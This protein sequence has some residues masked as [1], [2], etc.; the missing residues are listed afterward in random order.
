VQAAFSDAL[1]AGND[2]SGMEDMRVRLRARIGAAIYSFFAAGGAAG[3]TA[4]VAGF[5]GAAGVAEAAGAAWA[6]DAGAVGAGGFGAAAAAAGAF[7]TAEGFG[8]A[9]RNLGVGRMPE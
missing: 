3:A 4:G 1:R 8:S 5:A 7:A 9:R 6:G 2:E